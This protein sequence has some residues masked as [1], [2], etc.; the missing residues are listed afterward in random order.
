[1]ARLMS[2]VLFIILMFLSVVSI[3]SV[4]TAEAVEIVVRVPDGVVLE[5]A[6]W[7]HYDAEPRSESKAEYVTRKLFEFATPI[8][9][10]GR[11]KKPEDAGLTW[12]VLEEG[13]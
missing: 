10:F 6:N 11:F 13:A 3:A 5:A 12:R 2:Y 1:M 4:G 8:A 9:S 7:W